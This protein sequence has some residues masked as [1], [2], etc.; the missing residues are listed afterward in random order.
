MIITK[1]FNWKKHEVADEDII[2]VDETGINVIPSSKYTPA[3]KGRKQV[4]GTAKKSRGQITKITGIAKSGELLPYM[5][6]F[7][8]KTKNSTPHEVIPSS[9]S[10]YRS[11]LNVRLYQQLTTKLRHSHLQE[12]RD[13][14]TPFEGAMGLPSEPTRALVELLCESRLPFSLVGSRPFKA[15]V[16]AVQQHKDWKVPHRTTISGPELDKLYK[17]VI[18]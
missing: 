8:G 15:F 18:H 3:K 2:N 5:L 17:T 16:S 9:G 13:L 14:I 12:I 6:I 7:E 10:F 11:T 1:I 4:P